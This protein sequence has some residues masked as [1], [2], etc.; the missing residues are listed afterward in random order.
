MSLY[1]HRY[2]NGISE[3]IKVGKEGIKKKQKVKM[4]YYF[5]RWDYRPHNLFSKICL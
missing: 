5:Y 1:K 3:E 4:I 2:T